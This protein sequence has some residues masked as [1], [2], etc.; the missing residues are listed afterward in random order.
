MKM[1]SELLSGVFIKV[2][3]VKE[4]ICKFVELKKQTDDDTN[5]LN[6]TDVFLS[7]KYFEVMNFL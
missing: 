5:V 1:M 6:S 2:K 3:Y 4:N 7:C